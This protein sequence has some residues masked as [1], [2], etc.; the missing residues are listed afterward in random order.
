[1][2]LLLVLNSEPWA[3]PRFR[4]D[5]YWTKIEGFMDVVTTAWGGLPA[6]T[7]ADA[8]RSLDSK[9]RSLAKALSS[10]RASCVG[11]IMLE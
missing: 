11:N 2:A 8:C 5:G 6:G 9:L 1:M 7:R 10:W 3:T 4:F